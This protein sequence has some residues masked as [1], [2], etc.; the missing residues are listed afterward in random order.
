MKQI[1]NVIL[2]LSIVIV[3]VGIGMLIYGA[4]MFTY[5]GDFTRFERNLGEICF[6]FCLP[7]TFV[8]VL[9]FASA[10]V[11]KAIERAKN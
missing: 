8:G 2:V 3:L 4:H 1:L 10:F 5:R 6:V 9:L 11:V 7:V